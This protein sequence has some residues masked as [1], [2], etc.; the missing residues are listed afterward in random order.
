MLCG[1]GAGGDIYAGRGVCGVEEAGLESAGVDL[2]AGMVGALYDDGGSG[3]AGVETVWLC[4][5]A[6]DAGDLFCAAGAECV[7]VAVVLWLAVDGDRV[8][9][10]C[11]DV[12]RDPDDG[13]GFPKGFPPGGVVADAVS[14]VGGVRVG[15]EW[16]AV[17]DESGLISLLFSA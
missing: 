17:V 15:A 5:S 13:G 2:W 10:D 11:P 16:D 9:G 7:V 14:T 1:G 4:G 6:D 12:V 8:C 3:L